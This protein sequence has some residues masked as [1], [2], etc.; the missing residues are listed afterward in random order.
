MERNIRIRFS[1]GF[2]LGDYFLVRVYKMN[3]L[4]AD[5]YKTY[6][7]LID[8][9]GDVWHLYRKLITLNGKGTN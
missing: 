3:N 5:V 9:K 4:K 7:K 8:L 6:R 1:F 2:S